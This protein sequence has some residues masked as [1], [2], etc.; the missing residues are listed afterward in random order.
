[1]IYTIKKKKVCLIVTLMITQLAL[2]SLTGCNKILSSDAGRAQELLETLITEPA[3]M[4]KLYEITLNKNWSAKNITPVV[5]GQNTL[6]YLRARTKQNQSLEYKVSR[7]TNLSDKRS[8]V[9]VAIVEPSSGVLR[10]KKFRYVFRVFFKED[11]SGNNII[12]SCE[13]LN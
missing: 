8:Y 4:N 6:R 10:K 2:I 7:K 12:V 1:M 13:N 3:N 9:E 5:H 11:E